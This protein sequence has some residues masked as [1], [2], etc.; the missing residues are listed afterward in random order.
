MPGNLPVQF[1]QE[2][3]GW[4]FREIVTGE[5]GSVAI[6]FRAVIY[7]LEEIDMLLCGSRPVAFV[8]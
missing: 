3:V 8:V 4:I 7:E 5:F 1:E 2:F 6:V